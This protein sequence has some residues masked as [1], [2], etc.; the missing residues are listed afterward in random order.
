LRIKKNIKIVRDRIISVSKNHPEILE[1]KDPFGLFVFDGFFIEN[2]M[3][4]SYVEMCKAIELSKEK[5]NEIK[6][7]NS[8]KRKR[9]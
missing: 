8:K 6:E 2:E 3:K 5:I 9:S 7:A 1:A 4:I